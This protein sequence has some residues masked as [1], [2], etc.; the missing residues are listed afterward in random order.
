MM[1]YV[2]IAP[3]FPQNF[4]PFVVELRK[5]GVTVTGIGQEPYDR[6]PEEL[7]YLLSIYYEVDDYIIMIKYIAD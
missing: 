1:N 6:L 5:K 4:I 7:K 3:H 2:Y